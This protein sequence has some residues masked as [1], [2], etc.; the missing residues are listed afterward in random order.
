MDNFTLQFVQQAL[1]NEE[2]KRVYATDNVGGAS[3]MST[4][5]CRD[6]QAN[7][8]AVG[9][10]RSK[11]NCYKCEK[12]EHLKCNCPSM[13]NKN[14][15]HKA[16][17]M[18]CEDAEDSSESAFIAKEAN[19]NEMPHQVESLID[20]GASKHMTC[21]KEILKDYKE[22]SKPQ[23]VKLGDSRVVDA[24]GLGNI[25]LKML[26]KVSDVKDVT[27]YDVVYVPSGLGISY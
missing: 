18:T 14:Q 22:F 26:F 16:E 13:T 4:Q 27:M 9:A 12:E 21:C 10:D 7:S 23:S 3:A 25:K 11:W 2:Q 20:S 8:K 1:M 6:M 19:Q 15:T 17:I 24:Q 5:V